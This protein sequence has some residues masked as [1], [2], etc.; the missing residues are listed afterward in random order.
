M[1]E[2]KDVFKDFKNHEQSG[3]KHRSAISKFLKDDAHSVLA[4]TSIQGSGKT[5]A[6][7]DQFAKSKDAI[8]LT[9]SNDKIDE[10]VTII[11][12][13]HPDLEYKAIYG[14]ERACSTFLDSGYILSI[15]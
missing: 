3:K 15:N 4:I 14:L 12:N 11:N 1:Y 8:L 6:I 13:R 9:Q 2:P 5:T 7:I 10:L